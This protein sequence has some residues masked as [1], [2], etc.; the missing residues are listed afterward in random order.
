MRSCRRR[1]TSTVAVEPVGPS[2]Q[3]TRSI[4]GPGTVTAGRC[5]LYWHRPVVAGGVPVQLVVVGE[6]VQ[7]I[8]DRVADDIALLATDEAVRVADLDPQVRTVVVQLERHGRAA[9][10]NRYLRYVDEAVRL[11]VVGVLHGHVAKDAVAFERAEVDAQVLRGIHGP[12]RVHDVAGV[13][14]ADDPALLRAA[15]QRERR[16]RA[17]L[18]PARSTR[19]ERREPRHGPIVAAT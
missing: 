6:R 10:G 12:V 1:K 18:V 4:P 7:T 15:K 19:Q 5:A 14:G 17:A 13:E 11:I 2:K 3:A 16:M 9:V 8:V